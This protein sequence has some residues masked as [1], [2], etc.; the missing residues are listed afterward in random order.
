MR[1]DRVYAESIIETLSHGSAGN[2]LMDGDPTM[3]WLLGPELA[4]READL[5]ERCKLTRAFLRLP[6][7]IHGSCA[8]LGRVFH[9]LEKDSDELEYI[10]TTNRH[11][12]SIAVAAEEPHKVPSSVAVIRLYPSGYGYEWGEVLLWPRRIAGTFGSDSELP[13]C[14]RDPTKR[15]EY[16]AFDGRCA[17]LSHVVEREHH[18]LFKGVP[19]IFVCLLGVSPGAQGRRHAGRLLKTVTEI[20]DD[21]HLPCYLETS[22]GR[23]QHI[24]SR[25]GFRVSSTHSIVY[26][27][28]DQVRWPPLMD[29]ACMTRAPESMREVNAATAS[30]T[31]GIS[32]ARAR[33]V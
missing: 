23:L 21:L 6:I 18:R 32:L 20:A 12:A 9:A 15:S 26:P 33:P 31:D 3:H 19:H 16:D 14:F 24:F 28:D 25:Y 11:L 8:S 5:E 1:K 22:G 10:S 17:A 30:V 4:D 7:G 27:G 13:A 2:M 29:L